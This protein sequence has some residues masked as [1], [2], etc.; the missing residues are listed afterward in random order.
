RGLYVTL[1][2]GKQ[3]TR[4]KANLPTV[5]IYEITLHPRDN[6]MILATH[7][8]GVWVLDDLTPFQQFAIARSKDAFLFDL[9]AATQMNP[10]NDRSRDFEGDMQFLG[11]NPDAGASFNYFLKAPAKSLSIVVKDSSGKVARELSGDALKGKTDAG[12][13]TATWDLRV[14]PLPQPR[15]QQQ[16]PGGGGGGFGGGGLNGPFI[17]PGQYQVTLKVDGKEIAT[18]TFTVQG[19]PEITIAEADRRA[20]FDAAMELHRMQRTFNEAS[21][22]VGAINQRLTAM[23]QAMKDN[24]DAPAALKTKVEE[25]AKKF[26]PVGRQFGVGMGDPL[27]TGDFES[28]ARALR[29]RIGQLKNGVMASTS[30]PTETQ[31]RQIP[32]VRAAMEK[33]IQDAN[34]LIGEF[35]SLQKEMAESGVYPASVKPI[36]ADGSKPD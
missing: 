26:Q 28:F 30:R 20:A 11:K 2:R 25:F 35:A 7:G 22:S 23:Q 12:V 14:E 13:N 31:T 21:D 4:V 9:R 33:A 15:V 16:G 10:A 3:W 36:Q 8:R 17:M 32:E 19:D 34:Q 1:D 24:K 5:P 6:A 18:N 29:S 27:V